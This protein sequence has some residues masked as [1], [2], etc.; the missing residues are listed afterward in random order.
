VWA[1]LAGVAILAPFASGPG[2]PSWTVLSS[3]IGYGLVLPAIAILHVKHQQMRESGAVLGTAAG[4]ATVC[5]G[6]AISG[7]DT[8]TIGAL[9]VR[10]IW[11]WT[12]GKLWWETSLLPSWLALVTVALALVAFALAA[13]TTLGVASLVLPYLASA[14]FGL[15]L[16]AL[17]YALWRI[18]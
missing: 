2:L 14:L 4:V 7:N 5:L 9:F 12:V 16:I 3:A 8:L 13:G 11:W 15:W 1:A 18:R 6:I 10:G 17:S